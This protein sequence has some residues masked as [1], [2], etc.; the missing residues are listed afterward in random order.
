MEWEAYLRFGLALLFV[1]GLIGLCG[2]AARR[3][4]MTPKVSAGGREKRLAVVEVAA[5]DAKRRLVLVRRDDREHL[6]L[7]GA[8]QDVVVESGIPADLAPRALQAA[9]R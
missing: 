4:G 1:L 6:L 7:L 9:A 8:A 3:L 2:W 5:V